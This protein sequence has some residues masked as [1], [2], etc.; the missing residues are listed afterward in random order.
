MNK[1]LQIKKLKK[2][3]KMKKII[4]RMKNKNESTRLR[5]VQNKKL[6]KK[7][8]RTDAKNAKKIA[9]VKKLSSENLL[10]NVFNCEIKT[11]LKNN[12]K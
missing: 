3:K 12:Q 11:S 6:L 1:E 5:I 9:A 7:I 4:V 8:Q 10:L 2:I